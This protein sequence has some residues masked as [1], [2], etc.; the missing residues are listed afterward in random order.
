MAIAKLN[1]RM[2]T[3]PGLDELAS[4]IAT[5]EQ[6]FADAPHLRLKVCDLLLTG[7]DHRLKPGFVDLVA[8]P[9]SR[10]GDPPTI[11]LQVS[12]QFRELVAAT[13]AEK[14]ELLS[15]D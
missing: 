4:L 10:A 6:V 12:D 3:Q 2:D 11:Q 5:L 13:V 15:I 9:A 14:L 8:V 7:S 1:I